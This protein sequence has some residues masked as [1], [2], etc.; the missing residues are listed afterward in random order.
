MR[1]IRIAF[2]ALLGMFFM[3]SSAFAFFHNTAKI[4]TRSGIPLPALQHGLV[5]PINNRFDA[6]LALSHRMLTYGTWEEQARAEFIEV[7]NFTNNANT[8]TWW[9]YAPGDVL[10]SDANPWHLPTHAKLR[11]AHELMARLH[12]NFGTDGTVVNLY[13]TLNNET[14]GLLGICA[15]SATGFDTSLPVKPD[16]T[17]FADA[18]QEHV[19][20]HTKQ[21]GTAFLVL[22]AGIAMFVATQ[23]WR[24][25]H[26]TRRL[27]A[28]D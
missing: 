8:Q 25:N 1:F 5:E 10:N 3:A 16:W 4:E 15:Y 24:R 12:A 2:M 6:I 14:Y 11:G 7:L 22:L 21:F 9:G 28:N 27:L 23:R 20:L 13:D 17:H 18:M 19:S 26:Y